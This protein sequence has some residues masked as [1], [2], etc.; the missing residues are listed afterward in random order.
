MRFY[1]GAPLNDEAWV[2][3]SGILPDEGA[4]FSERPSCFVRRLDDD[5]SRQVRCLRRRFIDFPSP[6]GYARN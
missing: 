3:E 5:D 1:N 4:R 2:N 6:G